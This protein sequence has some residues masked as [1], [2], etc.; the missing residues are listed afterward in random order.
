M[1]ALHVGSLLSSGQS[2]SVGLPGTWSVWSKA[3]DAPGAY[4]L[5]PA[6]DPARATGLK[7][8]VVKA[9]MGRSAAEPALS[10][11]R[12]DPHKPEFTQPTK[13]GARR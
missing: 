10:I 9:V 11:V 13:S 3:A 6:S 4:F 12:T 2:E 8:V 5:T 1:S 7:Y